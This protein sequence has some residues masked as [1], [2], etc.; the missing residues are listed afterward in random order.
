MLKP[1]VHHS[2]QYIFCP[3]NSDKNYLPPTL[4]SAPLFDN[5]KNKKTNKQ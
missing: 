5:I 1:K 4:P 3:S 2:S